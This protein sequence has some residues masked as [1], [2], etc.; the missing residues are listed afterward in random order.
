MKLCVSHYHEQQKVAQSDFLSD[1]R[2]GILNYFFILC[3]FY[4]IRHKNANELSDF[5]QQKNN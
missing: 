2:K 3:L 1:Q 4:P 5:K